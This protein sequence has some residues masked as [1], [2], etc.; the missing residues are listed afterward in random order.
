M[1]AGMV[2]TA[3]ASAAGI[4]LDGCGWSSKTAATGPDTG[5]GPL[6]FAVFN[7]F[8]GPDA[9]FGPE[10]VAGCLPAA[11][12]IQ[13]A[14]GILDHKRVSCKPADTRGDPADA[15]PAAEQLIASPSGVMGVL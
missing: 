1:R 10:Q 6:T 14:G 7:P 13:A 15:V 4:A 12:A 9:S 2:L 5:T 11:A 8:S 3:L